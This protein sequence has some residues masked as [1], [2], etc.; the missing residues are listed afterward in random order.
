MVVPSQIKFK[1]TDG[2]E[3]F[4][5]RFSN[6]C[7]EVAQGGRRGALM[8]SMDIR[9]PDVEKFVTMKHDLTK[10]TGAN[11]SVKITD[12]FMKAVEA[13]EDFE[14]RFPVDSSEPKFKKTIKEQIKE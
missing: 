6:S 10:V 7:R 5:D 12:E 11:V 14:L 8:I 2:I 1:S 13:D 3:V 9:H 4:M